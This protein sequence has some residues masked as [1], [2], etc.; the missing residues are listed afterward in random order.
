MEIKTKLPRYL[1]Q[2]ELPLKKL[3]KS[4]CSRGS[5]DLF[6]TLDKSEDTSRTTTYHFFMMANLRNDNKQENLDVLD[7]HESQES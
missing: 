3:V 4:K 6:I 7:I 2:L 1:T 5:L